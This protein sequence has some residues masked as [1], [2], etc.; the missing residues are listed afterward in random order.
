MGLVVHVFHEC[1]CNRVF[2]PHCVC[3]NATDSDVHE[4]S[5]PYVQ[6]VVSPSG[7]VRSTTEDKVNYALVADGPML[8]RWAV[9]MTKGCDK[10]EKRNWMKGDEGDSE[11]FRE[12]AFRHFMQWWHGDEGEDHGAAIYFNINGFEYTKGKVKS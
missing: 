12:S 8:E 1:R 3:G 7:M 6:A 9:H 11:R 5:E 2:G 4:A 10:Y